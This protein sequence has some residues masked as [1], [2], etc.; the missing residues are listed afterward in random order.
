M[1]YWKQMAIM[2]VR[3]MQLTAQRMKKGLELDVA[4]VLNMG[5]YIGTDTN[6]TYEIYLLSKGLS[7]FVLDWLGYRHFIS[8]MKAIYGKEKFLNKHSYMGDY[9]I[10]DYQDFHR[11]I[12]EYHKGILPNPI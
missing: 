4:N 11:W 6:D 9:I 3:Y 12:A 2:L 5:K 10:Q 8:E 1:P 7:S